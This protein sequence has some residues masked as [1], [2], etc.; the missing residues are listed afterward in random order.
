[1]MQHQMVK[2]RRGED[3]GNALIVMSQREMR[4]CTY[5]FKVQ[6]RII[7]AVNRGLNA[8]LVRGGMKNRSG[9]NRDA[10]SN[11]DKS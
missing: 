11:H 4:V 9:S 8:L 1:M 3:T 2:K 5:V 10:T 6:Y 7:F